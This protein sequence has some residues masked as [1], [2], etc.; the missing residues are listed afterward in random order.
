MLC[1]HEVV[2]CDK[3]DPDDPKPCEAVGRLKDTFIF[4]KRLAGGKRSV[5]FTSG[6]KILKDYREHNVRAFYLDT[7]RETAR[8]E[9]PEWVANDPELINLTHAVC[10]DQAQKGRGYPVALAEAHEHAVV[11]GPERAAFYEM[12]ER[13]FIKHG[14]PISRSM[15]RISKNY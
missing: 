14:A 1:D 11:R 4:N 7:G 15:K 9:V 6:S 13:S 8:I 5:L 10:C 12:I 2:D 3:C